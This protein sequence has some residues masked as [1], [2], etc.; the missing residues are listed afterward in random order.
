MRTSIALSTRRATKV[1]T[2]TATGIATR[3]QNNEHSIEIQSNTI[4]T[5]LGSA[6]K[7]ASGAKHGAIMDSSPN[8]HPCSRRT[9]FHRAPRRTYWPT[10]S[11]RIKPGHKTMHEP[12]GRCA[13]SYC[14]FTTGAVI[15]PISARLRGAAKLASRVK[16]ETI[17]ELP[18]RAKGVSSSQLLKPR[19]AGSDVA[20]LGEQSWVRDVFWS[21]ETL[22]P[23][24]WELGDLGSVRWTRWR[25]P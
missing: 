10:A 19:S 3:Y 6:T 8:S 22:G 13:V 2:S 24:P 17:K 23:H 18:S 7:R 25:V 20:A 4:S 14:H 12:V 16:V 9:I 5:T 15:A 11:E 21:V 1:V